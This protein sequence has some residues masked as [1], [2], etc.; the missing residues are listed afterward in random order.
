MTCIVYRNLTFLEETGWDHR[1]L[2]D[3]L[4]FP[5]RH[6]FCNPDD[7]A[8]TN[9]TVFVVIWMMSKLRMQQWSAVRREQ[10]GS[11]YSFISFELFSLNACKRRH[12]VFPSPIR[13]IWNES[14]VILDHHSGSRPNFIRHKNFYWHA[15]TALI[16]RS[17]PELVFSQ[18]NS[19]N[20]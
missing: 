9:F 8:D 15:H 1:R 14:T 18:L 3:S 4:E 20:P 5:C 10:F 2:V 19:A 17:G 7:P 16:S 12:R 11:V 6:T 13:R